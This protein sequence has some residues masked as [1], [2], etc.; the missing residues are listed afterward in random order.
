MYCIVLL[1]CKFKDNYLRGMNKFFLWTTGFF[2]LAFLLDFLRK[3]A[4]YKTQNR[5]GKKQGEKGEG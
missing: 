2:N 3:N 4:E 5:K 1:N